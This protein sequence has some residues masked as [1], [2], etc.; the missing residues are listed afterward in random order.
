MPL[1][2]DYHMIQ[3]LP[4]D[5]ANEPLDIRMLPRTL[6][7]SQ[8]FLDA[9]MSHTL[10]KMGAVDMVPIAEERAWRLVPRERLDHL[11][12]RPLGRWMLGDVEVYNASALVSQDHEHEEHAERH[13]RDD[14]EIQGDQVLHMVLQKRLPRWGRGFLESWT[15]FLDGGFRHRDA[16]LPEFADNP[17]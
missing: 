4:P 8:H 15:I 7:G 2:E 14:K 12:G 5:T 16:E 1:M 6:W 9:H 11:L 10:P 3:T 13:R 17:R